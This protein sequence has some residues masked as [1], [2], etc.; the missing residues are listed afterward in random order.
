MEK[1]HQNFPGKFCSMQLI[2]HGRNCYP[3]RSKYLL[4]IKNLVST[5]FNG[6]P[7][8]WGLASRLNT[9]GATKVSI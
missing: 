6:S 2:M 3:A 5:H 8:F 4:T 1:K 7:D 9:L